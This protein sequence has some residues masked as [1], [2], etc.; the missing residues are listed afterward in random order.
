[1]KGSTWDLIVLFG[2]A[3][4]VILLCTMFLLMGYGFGTNEFSLNILSKMDNSS[5][6]PNSSIA[7][8]VTCLNSD[9]KGWFEYNTNNT[10]KILTEDDLRVEGGVC[11]HAT[12]WYNN[13]LTAMG[14]RTREVYMLPDDLVNETGHVF[15]VA[16]DT[17]VNNYCVIDSYTFTCMRL[18]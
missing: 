2:Q 16:Y 5:N 15:L 12:T 1:M 6:C 4:V 8:A 7:E 11:T 3:S 14:Y 10:G 17:K 9:F 18:K 13:K